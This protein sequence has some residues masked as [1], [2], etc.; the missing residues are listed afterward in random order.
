[1]IS[2]TSLQISI[3][4]LPLFIRLVPTVFVCRSLADI[5]VLCG[6]FLASAASVPRLWPAARPPPLVAP[7][8]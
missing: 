4:A 5:S 3:Q 2:V 6:L 1:M 8:K 7:F